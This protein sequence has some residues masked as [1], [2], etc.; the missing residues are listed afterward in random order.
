MVDYF[1][2]MFAYQDWANDKLLAYLQEHPDE[3]L[4]T[5]FAHIIADATP[6][7]LLV[8][9]R[10]IPSDIDFSPN[11]SL[12]ECRTHLTQYQ[13]ETKAFIENLTDEGLNRVMSSPGANGATF[14]N[15]V[16]EVLTSILL[17]GQ[18][19]RGQMEWIIEQKTGEHL[20]TFYLPFLRQ[21][22]Q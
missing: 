20:N 18:H 11:W 22:A 16:A 19:H 6:W 4:L 13:A 7:L 14:E 9:G 21:Q 1:R 8:Q 2:Q 3:Q 17:H 12:E 15:T 10:P 5:M